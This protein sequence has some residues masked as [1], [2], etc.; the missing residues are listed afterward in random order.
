MSNIQQPR[1]QRN[2][3]YHQSLNPNRNSGSYNNQNFN[4]YAQQPQFPTPTPPIQTYQPPPPRTNTDLNLSVLRRHLPSISSILSIAANAV[5]YT[6]SPSTQAWEKAGIEGTLFICACN[7]TTP[8]SEEDHSVIILNRRNLDNWI[9][10]LKAVA[11][12][13]WMKE[14]ELLVLRYTPSSPGEAPSGERV[15]G[16]W[17]HEDAQGTR[18]VNATAILDSWEKAKAAKLRDAELATRNLALGEESDREQM[19][20]TGPVR[21]PGMGRPRASG[22]PPGMISGRQVS[23]AELFGR[24]M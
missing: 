8:G 7:P 22:G 3:N 5:L 6:F 10:N 18:E 15:Y 2:Y 16:L 11:D 19:E 12:V 14:G 13:E 9:V 23:M 24:Q 17:I 20:G 4:Q 21:H 1:P